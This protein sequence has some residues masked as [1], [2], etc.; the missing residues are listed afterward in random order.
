MV[1]VINRVTDFSV[2]LVR[3]YRAFHRTVHRVRVFDADC[4]RL[5]GTHFP[6]SGPFH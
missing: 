3:V 6:G 4:S 1:K 5:A 2:V